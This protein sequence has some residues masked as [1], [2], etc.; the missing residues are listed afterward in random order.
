MEL[1]LRVFEV[2][3]TRSG[4]NKGVHHVL[5]I[6]YVIIHFHQ[7]SSFH[8]IYKAKVDSI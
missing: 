8:A 4:Q 2:L 1:S 5:I 3:G 7:L 6:I